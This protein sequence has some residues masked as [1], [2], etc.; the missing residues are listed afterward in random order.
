MR[1][2]RCLQ[3]RYGT[4]LA[5]AL[6]CLVRTAVASRAATFTVINTN[7]LGAGS[8]RQA[9][10]DAN[11]TALGSLPVVDAFNRMRV[12]DTNVTQLGGQVAW[13]ALSDARLKANIRDLDLGL[14]FVSALRPVAFTLRQG[15]AS[16]G[17]GF[18]AQA[19]FGGETP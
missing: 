8:L 13:S 14:D 4:H 19:D 6:A 10:L 3:P 5:L 18:L 12:G 16:T 2:R 1:S 15:D 7:D 9:I 17:L 11:A